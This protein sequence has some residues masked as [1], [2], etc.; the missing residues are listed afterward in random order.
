M[1][2]GMGFQVSMMMDEC[3]PDPSGDPAQDAAWDANVPGI[4]EMMA[5]FAEKFGLSL[6]SFSYQTWVGMGFDSGWAAGRESV[7]GVTNPALH[8]ENS[9]PDGIICNHCRTPWPCDI[10]KANAAMGQAGR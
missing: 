8:F 1:T 3:K 9:Q 7:L 10:Q 5:S 4:V 2:D 6:D